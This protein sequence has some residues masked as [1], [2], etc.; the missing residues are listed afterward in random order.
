M[1]DIEL[2]NLDKRPEEEEEE[3]EDQ[4]EETNVDTDWRDER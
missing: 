4:E 1:D 3:P 2:D